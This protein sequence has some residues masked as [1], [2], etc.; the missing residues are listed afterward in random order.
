[1]SDKI[2]Q[3][4]EYLIKYDLK[5]FVCN[6]VEETLN[7][8]LYK[9]ADEKVKDEKYERSSNWQNIVPVIISGISVLPQGKWN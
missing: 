5:N 4:K 9:E 1:M 6:S 8:L 2:I 7:V 3:L